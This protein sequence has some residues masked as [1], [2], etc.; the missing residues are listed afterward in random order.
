[1]LNHIASE[2]CEG[3]CAIINAFGLEKDISISSPGV[4]LML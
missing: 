3:M 4:D 2:Y 1:M